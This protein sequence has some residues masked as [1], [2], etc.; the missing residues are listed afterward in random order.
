MSESIAIHSDGHAGHETRGHSRLLVGGMVGLIVGVLGFAIVESSIGIVRSMLPTQ[1]ATED[2]L[3]N[4]P[5]REFPR[6]WRMDRKAVN[7]DHIYGQ[8]EGPGLDWI[9]EPGAGD[10]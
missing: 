6:E 9:R 1:E 3:A 10:P 7:F 8:K 4:L 2:F 5:G